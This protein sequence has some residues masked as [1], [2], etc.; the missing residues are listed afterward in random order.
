MFIEIA[1][2][3]WCFNIGPGKDAEGNVVLPDPNESLDE[4]LVV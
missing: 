3:L 1:C 4:G 2:I